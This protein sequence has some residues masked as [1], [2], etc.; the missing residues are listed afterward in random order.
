MATINGTSGNDELRGGD[1]NDTLNGLAGGD[2]LLGGNGND[3][4]VGGAGADGYVGGAGADR[5]KMNSSSEADWDWIHDFNQADGDKI[6]LGSIDAVAN[7]W[8]NPWTWDE[9]GFNFIHTTDFTGMAGEVR[10][11]HSDGVTYVQGS[12]DS[13]TDAEFTIGLTGIHDLTFWDFGL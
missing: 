7:K 1:E 12:T 4:L 6:D 9:Q 11:E 5:F 10:Y 13:D 3:I 2:D 8:W